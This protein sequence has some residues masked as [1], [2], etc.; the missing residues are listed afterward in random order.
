MPLQENTVVWVLRPITVFSS[1]FSVAMGGFDQPVIAVD[2][3]IDED[4]KLVR[5]SSGPTTLL[6]VLGRDVQP[7]PIITGV[8]K[9][10]K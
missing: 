7:D 5:T 3:S 9:V 8:V 1:T 4:F 10:Y 2:F 6:P